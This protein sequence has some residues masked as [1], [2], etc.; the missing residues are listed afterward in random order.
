MCLFAISFIVS[1]STV[2][3]YLLCTCVC[4][5]FGL[6]DVWMREWMGWDEMGES[7]GCLFFLFVSGRG[8]VVGFKQKTTQF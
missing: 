3:G 5:S 4:V 8:W 1:F 6:D 2:C 7:S